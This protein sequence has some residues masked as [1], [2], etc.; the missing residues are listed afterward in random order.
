MWLK[1]STT[2]LYQVIPKMGWGFFWSIAIIE[3]LVPGGVLVVSMKCLKQYGN[4]G[5]NRKLELL[6]VT[7]GWGKW[8]VF[9]THSNFTIKIALLYTDLITSY[10]STSYINCYCFFEIASKLS[11]TENVLYLHFPLFY[12]SKYFALFFFCMIVILAF[13]TR[14]N[15]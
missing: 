15:F 10:T 9:K 6:R 4:W 5:L 11:C 1:I 13:S 7:S 3:G 2:L 8:Y 14:D 12:T